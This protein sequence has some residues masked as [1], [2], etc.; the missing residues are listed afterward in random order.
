M[1]QCG[2]REVTGARMTDSGKFVRLLIWKQGGWGLEQ[3]EE[4]MNRGQWWWVEGGKDY[5][6]RMIRQ[7]VESQQT[8][9]H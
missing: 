6:K 8:K 2:P 7:G 5:H 4:P 1:K 9:Q 3:R